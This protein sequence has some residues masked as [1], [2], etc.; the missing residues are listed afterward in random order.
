MSCEDPAPLAVR[1]PREIKG[2][3]TPDKMPFIFFI[4]R[5]LNDPDSVP[6]PNLRKVEVSVQIHGYLVFIICMGY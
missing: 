1:E 6:P 4:Q 5:R 2:K 3:K